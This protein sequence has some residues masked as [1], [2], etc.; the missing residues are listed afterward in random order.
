MTIGVGPTPPIQPMDLAL[1]G[2]GKYVKFL[3]ESPCTSV[4]LSGCDDP[5]C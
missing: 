4:L 1:G 2:T 3:H 5:P